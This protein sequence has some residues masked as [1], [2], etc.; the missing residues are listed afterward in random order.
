MAHYNWLYQMRDI[1]FQIKEWLD[2]D[3]LL[4][5][6]AYKDYYALDDVDNF[7]DLNFRICRD[8]MCPALFIDSSITILPSSTHLMSFNAP[9][10]VPIGVRQ[11]PVTTISLDTICPPLL[12]KNIDT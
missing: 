2:M 9:P 10:K 6:D 7:L 1:K 5:L 8:V 12:H 4:S 11:R 3:T